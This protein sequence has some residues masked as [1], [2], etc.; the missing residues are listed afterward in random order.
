MAKHEKVCF[1]NQHAFI[2]F[3]FDIF[4]FLA[5]KADDVLHSVQRAMHSKVMSYLLGP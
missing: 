5:P 4:G 1:D 2:P 3:A